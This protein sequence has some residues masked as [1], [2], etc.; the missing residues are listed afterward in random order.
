[1]ESDAFSPMTERHT[2]FGTAPQPDYAIAYAALA[3]MVDAVYSVDRAGRF[4][5]ANA[6]FEAMTGYTLAA[7]RGTPAIRL[8]VPE[9]GALFTERRR[10]MDRGITVPPVV[11]T[12]LIRKNEQ[13]L[14]VELTMSNL[15]TESQSAGQVVV[16]RELT[17]HAP[18]EAAGHASQEQ[19][20]VVSLSH[21]T[22]ISLEPLWAEIRQ[23]M[24]ICPSFFKL[25]TPEP[26]IARALF[27]LAKLAYLD[28]PLPAVFKEKLFTYLSRFC[29]VQ[30][31]V[32]RHMAFLLGH[33]YVAGD[34][35]APTSSVEEVLALLDEP[36]PDKAE[37]S[38]IL[39]ELEGQPVPLSDW[40]VFDSHIGK[41]FRI[42]CASVFLEPEQ[43]ARWCQ[44]LGRL[45]GPK[46]YEQ[47]MLFMAFVRTAHFWT[48]VHPELALEG[49]VH[50]LLKEH[51][52]LA[53]SIR[54]GADQT[55]LFQIGERVA[56]EWQELRHTAALADA[57]RASEARLA[58]IL[59]Q[60]P[61]AVGV[62]DTNGQII[63]A[64]ALGRSYICQQIPSR[65]PE[66]PKRWRAFAA[67]GKLIAPSDWPGA[68]AL[69]GQSVPGMD[70][71]HMLDDGREIWLRISATPFRAGDGNLIGALCMMEDID[72]RKRAEQALRESEARFRST[73]EN[74]A[75]GIA[76][77][78]MGGHW[79]RVNGRLC[80]ITGYDRDE[81]LTR[82]FQDIT[83]PADLEENIAHLQKI[84]TGEIATYTTEKRYIR[85]DGDIIWIHVTVSLMRQSSGE[86]DYCISIIEDITRRKQA[87][88]ALHD[89]TA[90]LEQRVAERTTALE[91]A[92]A[93]QQRLER[94]AQR[95]EHFALLGR[96][97]AGV[98][99]ELRNPLAAVF[100]HVDLLAEEL[101]QP[102]VDSPAMLAEY[103]AELKL[104]L[105]RVDDLVQDYLSLVRVHAIQPEV[106][107]LSVAVAAWC[108]E[109]EEFVATHG[110]TIEQEG[111]ERLGTVAFHAST[112]RR[113]L[114][115]LVQNAA[116]AMPQ[117][118][119]ITL[120]GQSIADQV[121]LEVRDTGPG[122]PQSVWPSCLSPC[123]P[124]SRGGQGSAYIL[125]RRW[126]QHTAGR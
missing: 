2:T 14:P 107:D 34:S 56:A 38:A 118:G 111:L 113:A 1:M 15:I 96:L 114:L 48:E 87:E 77:V 101:A 26:T 99:H 9:A 66:S 71:L 109:F 91:Q 17:A 70:F 97:A 60:L 78:G 37:S 33:G 21:D 18:T 93:E 12:V 124:P 76:H 106:Q 122:L 65:D 63:L 83:H 120:A 51:E 20:Q 35:Q 47:L 52:A 67:D 54:N 126:P 74:A 32:A 30:Y 19:Q 88:S 121:L 94:E 8:Y 64:N 119:A 49:D 31:C 104:S 27:D 92:M 13:R 11:E 23:R 5:F 6:A 116:E 28:S 100:L 95:A 44:A 22:E 4:T 68:Q 16:M 79:L 39:A 62:V 40:P 98:S 50:T 46:R 73:F 69:R 61:V 115:N 10:L 80:E 123:I 55:R 75:V 3:S 103:L 42:A 105:A 90:T 57:L 89:L 7:L 43:S 117:G 102:S 110:V 86:P 85:K 84:Y 36:L 45:L 112:L 58:A 81:L 29:H 125:C 108:L 25:A 24:G 82:T 53:S 59:E 72:A 41:L